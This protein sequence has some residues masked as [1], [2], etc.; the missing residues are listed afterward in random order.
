M[1]ARFILSALA[2]AALSIRMAAANDIPL[3]GHALSDKQAAA[4]A[5]AV[6]VGELVA[7][8]PVK[9]AH[10]RYIGSVVQV[11]HPSNNIRAARTSQAT[12]K[13]SAFPTDLSLPMKMTVAPGEETPRVGS[14]YMF[15]AR[16]NTQR[17]ENGYIAVKLVPT[18]ER[19]LPQ[20]AF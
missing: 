3:P 9:G 17:G 8:D 15:Y 10:D 18:G 14:T 2:V 6:F 5:N 20:R 19:G 4:Q 16:D 1:N 12:I 7:L 11:T 13:T